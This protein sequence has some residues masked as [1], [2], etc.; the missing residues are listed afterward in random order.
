MFLFPTDKVIQYLTL[1]VSAVQNIVLYINGEIGDLSDGVINRLF[2]LNFGGDL[3]PR[4]WIISRFA[5]YLLAVKHGPG[6]IPDLAECIKFNSNPT[7]DHWILEMSQR[8]LEI[9]G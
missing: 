5:A 1:S 2:S 6:L 4:T 3:K 8:R 7:L 9:G